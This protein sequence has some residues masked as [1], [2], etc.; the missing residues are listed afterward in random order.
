MEPQRQ[1]KLVVHL[2]SVH[3]QMKIFILQKC[4]QDLEQ[5]NSIL[6]VSETLGGI[7]NRALC[8]DII[9]EDQELLNHIH[10]KLQGTRNSFITIFNESQQVAIDNSLLVTFLGHLKLKAENLLT[11]RDALGKELRIQ[12]KQFWNCKQRRKRY[13]RRI[14]N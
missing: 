7:Q 11:G 6:V 13:W 10:D 14:G 12:F 1:H 8:E 2:R 9:E 5:K 3:A 4:I